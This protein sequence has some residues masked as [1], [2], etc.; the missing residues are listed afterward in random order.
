MKNGNLIVGLDVG[1]TKTCVVVGE[2]CPV[3]RVESSFSPN[4]VSEIAIDIIGVG[5]APSTG[6]KKGVVVNIE[7]TA[8]S[9]KKAVKEAEVMADVEIKAVHVSIAG[10][11]IH[12]ASSHGVIAVKEREISQ[13]E[14]D[15]VIDAAKTIAFPLDREVLHIIPTGFVVDGQNGIN[16]PRGMSGV[17]LEANIQ[18][19]TSSVTSMQNIMKSCSIAG[20]QVIDVVLNPLASAAAVLNHDEKDIG[21]GLVDIGGGTTD[22]TLFYEG[23][24]CYSSVLNVGGNNFTNDI[25]IGLRI[26]AVEAEKIKKEHG[27][28]LMNMIRNNET[29]EMTYTEDRPSKRLSKRHLIEVL[30]P[31]A[32]ELLYLV[33]EEVIKSGFRGFMTSGIVLTGG[34]ALLQGLDIMAE[35]ILEL[36]VRIGNPKCIDGV[37]NG[38]SNPAYSTGAGLVLYG[39]R[40]AL[41]EYKLSNANLFNGLK[42]RMKGLVHKIVSLN[43]IANLKF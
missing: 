13:R 29:I 16:N 2:I 40:E 34:T 10:D 18:I 35:N 6:I 23:N 37:K 24:V 33:K 38:I 21:V 19:I 8:E 22:I 42:T 12:N 14:V 20:L 39:A 1:T 7:K 5:S 30:Q 4:S 17:R 28:A 27:C 15:R 11:H 32:E 9:I 3:E 26:P 41:A 31:R 43:K 36:P 25:A